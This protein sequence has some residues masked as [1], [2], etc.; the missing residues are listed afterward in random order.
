MANYNGDKI[1]GEEWNYLLFK[2]L[3]RLENPRTKWRL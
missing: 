3:T 1:S 2:S